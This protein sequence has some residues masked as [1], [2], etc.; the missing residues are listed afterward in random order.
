[1][2]YDVTEEDCFAHLEL[3]F[4]IQ[5]LSN[6]VDGVLGQTYQLSCQSRVKMAV[7]MPIMGG[8]EKFATSHLFAIDC[9]VSKFGLKFEYEKR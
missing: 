6:T 9:T 4:K 2:T 1:M 7:A 3:N 8:A 5:S